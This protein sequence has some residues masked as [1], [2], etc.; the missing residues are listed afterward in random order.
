LK[1]YKISSALKASHGFN[2]REEPV[3]DGEPG[4]VRTLTIPGKYRRKDE[5]P[6]HYITGADYEALMKEEHN[7][8]PSSFS[9]LCEQGING[10]VVAQEIPFSGLPPEFQK[11]FDPEQYAKMGIKEPVTVEEPKPDKKRK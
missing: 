4:K 10:G 7:G 5:N 1:Y 6:I 11:Q 2:W 8:Q 9:I 3:K